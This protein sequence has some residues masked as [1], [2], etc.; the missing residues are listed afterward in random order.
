M[1]QRP[2]LS[3]MAEVRAAFAIHGYTRPENAS[4]SAERR[5][6]VDC[7]VASLQHVMRAE[8]TRRNQED[9]EEG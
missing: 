3:S 4:A 5:N 1:A 2:D 7:L 8:I 6:L 9:E